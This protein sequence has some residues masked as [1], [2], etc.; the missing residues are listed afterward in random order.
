MELSNAE[1]K[2]SY[3]W[4][5][6][7][8]FRKKMLCQTLKQNNLTESNRF[9]IRIDCVDLA[10]G[11][12]SRVL[13]CFPSLIISI[14]IGWGSFWFNTWTNFTRFF[15]ACRGPTSVS[16]GQSIVYVQHA[17]VFDSY[18]PVCCRYRTPETFSST[19][20]SHIGKYIQLYTQ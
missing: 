17:S 14:M 16:F 19:N 8:R 11:S 2:Y 6:L 10:G 15:K 18:N 12:Y 3:T 20:N 9:L 13:V 5:I 1:D 4:N 7:I